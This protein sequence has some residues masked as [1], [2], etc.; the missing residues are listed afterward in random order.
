MCC[1]A[2]MAPLRSLIVCLIA[3]KESLIVS[4]PVQRVKTG[5]GGGG[6]GSSKEE[7]VE[8]GEGRGEDEEEKGIDGMRGVVG[9]GGGGRGWKG[10]GGLIFGTKPR[11]LPWLLNHST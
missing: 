1:I 4:F 9:G 3:S 2:L 8:S 11:E 6:G 5:E 7:V 10:G